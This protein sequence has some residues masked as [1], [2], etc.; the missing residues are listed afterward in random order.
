VE[1]ARANRELRASV[2][3]GKP[4][5]AATQRPG[6]FNDNTMAAREAGGHYEPPANRGVNA[7][8]PAVHPNEL[9]PLERPAAPSTGNP[10]LD[11]KYQQQQQKLYSNQVQERQKLQQKQEKEDQNLAKQ[12]ANAAQRQQVEQRHQQQTQQMQQRHVQ[13]QQQMQQKQQPPRQSGS[14]PGHP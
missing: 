9:P 12:N 10:R 6:T 11:Q 4:S 1:A 3:Q 14:R 5:V 8:R 13:R 7:A 2:N